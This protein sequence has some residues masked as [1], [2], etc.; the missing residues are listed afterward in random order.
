M[1]RTPAVSRPA[2][3]MAL[4]GGGGSERR[5]PVEIVATAATY[6]VRTPAADISGLY[7]GR[8]GRWT[9][10]VMAMRGDC[11]AF[12]SHWQA[13]NARALTQS[14]A[15]RGGVQPAHPRGGLGARPAGRPGVRPLPAALGREAGFRLLSSQPGWLP[16]VGPGAAGGPPINRWLA[17]P[18][19]RQVAASAC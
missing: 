9:D 11:A 10:G 1:Y 14:G 4:S 2:W 7:A 17:E 19:P 6:V 5:S 3:M 16:R 13:H 8:F 12:A 15:L 18:W